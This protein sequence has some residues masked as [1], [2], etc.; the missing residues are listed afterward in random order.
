[1]PILKVS[2]L[3][4]TIPTPVADTVY[5]VRVGSGFDIN[6]TNSSG[7]IVAY[8]LNNTLISKQTTVTFT[9][10]RIEQRFTIADTDV[11]ST[12]IINCFQSGLSESLANSDEYILL[13]ATPTNGSLIINVKASNN[14]NKLLGLFKINYTISN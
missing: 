5:F 12:S 14:Y 4:S 7:T 10:A 3:V 11:L 9:V 6:V 2:K 13:N 8:N 1:M